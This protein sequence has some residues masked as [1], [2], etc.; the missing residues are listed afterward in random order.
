MGKENIAE[1]IL[2]I[3]EGV[4]KVVTILGSIDSGLWIIKQIDEGSDES[5]E[6][7]LFIGI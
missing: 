3:D 5:L 1:L 6:V 7:N 4:F 2:K